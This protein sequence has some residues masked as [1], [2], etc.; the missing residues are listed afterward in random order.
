MTT[1][2]LILMTVLVMMMMMVVV[3][4]MEG[5]SDDN[6][7]YLKLTLV[8]PESARPSKLLDC[9]LLSDYWCE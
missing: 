4:M 9:C 1:G 6:E 5:P 7:D 2:L 3:V 8:C